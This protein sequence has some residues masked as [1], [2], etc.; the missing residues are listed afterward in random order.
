VPEETWHWHTKLAG[1]PATLER[2]IKRPDAH[3]T[4]QEPRSNRGVC[5]MPKL[6][7]TWISTKDGLPAPGQ[8][9]YGLRVIGGRV[10]RLGLVTICGVSWRP[11]VGG[12]ATRVTHWR[13]K[14]ATGG[15]YEE[16][17]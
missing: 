8:V 12:P 15:L 1:E 3:L 4:V 14:F 10:T 11:A 9:V 7:H 2:W 16:I 6:H 5:F 13:P 17:K